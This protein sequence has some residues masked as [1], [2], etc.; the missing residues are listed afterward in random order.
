M[1]YT[2]PL[3]GGWLVSQSGGWKEVQGEQQKN[4]KR[5]SDRSFMQRWMAE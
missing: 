1:T 2:A 3:I 4:Y 5:V